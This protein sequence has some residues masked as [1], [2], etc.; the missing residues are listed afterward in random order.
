MAETRR[1]LFRGGAEMGY[2]SDGR[3]GQIQCQACG[4]RFHRWFGTANHGLAHERRGEAVAELDTAAMR[5]G[6]H[7]TWNF[8]L[9]D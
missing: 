2:D 6:Y 3:T 4:R 1:P 5:L 7:V 8:F 9:P